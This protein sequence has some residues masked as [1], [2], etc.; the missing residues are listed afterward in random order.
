MTVV[1]QRPTFAEGVSQAES[2]TRRPL[3]HGGYLRDSGTH[4]LEV[5]WR[6]FTG[7]LTRGRGEAP[8]SISRI[9]GSEMPS[10]STCR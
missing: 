9:S 6:A 8:G 5:L 1:L 4:Q 2:L 3:C 7:L 10:V